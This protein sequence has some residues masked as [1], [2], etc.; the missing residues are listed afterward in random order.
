MSKSC[1]QVC[2]KS[3]EGDSQ[4]N[5]TKVRVVEID[6]SELALFLPRLQSRF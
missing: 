1:D 2:G 6:W 4:S 5:K 3:V